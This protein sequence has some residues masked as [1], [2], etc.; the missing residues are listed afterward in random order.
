ML[1]TMGVPIE[2]LV[3]KVTRLQF[4]DMT[5]NIY[6]GFLPLL[7]S[8]R[9]GKKLMEDIVKVVDSSEHKFFALAAAQEQDCLNGR[10]FCK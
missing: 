6:A 7:E 5:R 3:E 1:F 8:M 9:C 4:P 2:A 10:Y